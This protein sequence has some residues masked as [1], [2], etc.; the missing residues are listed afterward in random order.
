MT[1][2]GFYQLAV[3]LA[4]L[5]PVALKAFQTWQDFHGQQIN[6]EKRKQLAADIKEVVK[7]AIETRDTSGIEKA[8]KNLGKPGAPVVPGFQNP[9]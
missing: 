8:I 4:Q 5:F 9:S 6:R 1:I 7:T 3:L 2:Q